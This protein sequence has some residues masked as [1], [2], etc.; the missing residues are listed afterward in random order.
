MKANLPKV[1][2]DF[3]EECKTKEYGELFTHKHHIIPKFMGGTNKSDNLIILSVGD[4]LMAHKIL[5]ENCDKIYKR[6]AWDSVTILKK[7][8]GGNYD[9]ILENLRVINTGELNHFYGKRHTNETKQKMAKNHPY[10]TR[11]KTWKN[12]Y[13]N[14]RAIELS[15]KISQSKNLYKKPL[16]QLDTF[17]NIVKEWDSCKEA[18][19][20]TKIKKIIEC[21]K[22]NRKTAGG[23]IWKY[24]QNKNE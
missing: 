13:G 2:L 19:R 15:K 14:D 22:G 8:W 21:C 3:I 10:P 20:E 18:I 16:F 17:G 7:G 12:V 9:S 4:H 5:A 1:Y 23:F 6:N 11:G 24:K